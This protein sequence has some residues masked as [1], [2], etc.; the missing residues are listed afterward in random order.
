MQH[1]EDYNDFVDLILDTPTA[2]LRKHGLWL[3]Q[4]DHRLV[5]RQIEIDVPGLVSGDRITSRWEIDRILENL[6]ISHDDSQVIN[7]HLA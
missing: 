1:P 6:G 7:H 4:R 2:K 5:L 3:L